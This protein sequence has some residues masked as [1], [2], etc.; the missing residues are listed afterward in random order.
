MSRRKNYQLPAEEEINTLVSL[1]LTRPA[2]CG[3]RPAKTD[4]ENAGAAWQRG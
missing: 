4:R 3:R 2:E 1:A